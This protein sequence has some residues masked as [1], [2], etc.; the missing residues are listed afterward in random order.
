[1]KPEEIKTARQFDQT[2]KEYGD[3]YDAHTPGGHSFRARRRMTH[4]LVGPVPL[5]ALLDVGGASGVYFS[6]FKDRATSYHIVDISFPMVQLAK[7]LD[8]GSVPFLCYQASAYELPFLENCFDYVIAMGLLEYVDQPWD[9][10][11]EIARVS[12]PGGVILVSFLSA[13]SPMRRLSKRIYQLFGRP[14]PFGRRLMR[15]GEVRSEAS[16]CDLEIDAI[17]GYN[18]QVIPAPFLWRLRFLSYPLAVVLEPFLN[19]I[20]R[21]WGTSFVA[22]FRKRS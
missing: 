6:L 5:G 8:D 20:G 14:E 2:A 18:A 11:R 7:K 13:Y 21:L 3:E 15:I 19:R 22:K 1:M 4:K 16:R 10:V 12:R 9:V 17:S